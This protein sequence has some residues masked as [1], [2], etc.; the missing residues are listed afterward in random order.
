MTPPLATLLVI[1]KQPVAGRVKTR[2]VPPLTYEQAADVAG[3]ALWDTLRAMA[4]VPATH[5]LLAFDGEH[6]E[7]LPEGWRAVAQPDGGLDERLGAA[8]DA[9]DP[10]G[11]ALLVG[12]DTPQVSAADVAA[13][14]PSRYDACLGLAHDGGYWTIGFREPRAAR[15]AIAGVPMSTERTGEAQLE[16]LRACGMRVQLLAVMTDVDTIDTAR[17]V[18]ALVP[19]STF[20]RALARAGRR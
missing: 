6:R 7:W 18:A 16:R 2:L 11:P 4:H 19:G 17:E 9:A 13:F 3:A 14:D 12:M 1:A 15:A 5:R 8:F 20:A 10:D